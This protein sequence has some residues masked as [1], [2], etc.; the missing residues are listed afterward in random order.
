MKLLVSNYSRLHSPRIEGYRPPD[1]L[2]LCHLFSTEFVEPPPLQNKIPRYATGPEHGVGWC[3]HLGGNI[4]HASS[5]TMRQ[6]AQIVTVTI[7]TFDLGDL[8][9]LNVILEQ[10]VSCADD[11]RDVA[12]LCAHDFVSTI[13]DSSFCTDRCD[14]GK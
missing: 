2:S 8:H 14:L 9:Q 11:R 6:S 12:V 5:L 13:S 4:P 10:C 3:N 7:Q 1:L